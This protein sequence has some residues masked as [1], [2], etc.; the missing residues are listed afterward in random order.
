MSRCPSLSGSPPVSGL[1]HPHPAGW[2]TLLAQGT[3]AKDVTVEIHPDRMLVALKGAGVVTR[4]HF[5]GKVALDGCYWLM[6]DLSLDPPGSAELGTQDDEVRQGPVYRGETCV[7]VF[8][9][10]MK[11]FD[12]LWESVYRPPEDDGTSSGPQTTAASA[13]GVAGG[14]GGD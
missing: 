13:R 2:R 12:T 3:R 9:E 11:P 10:K 14:A 4:G 5:H 6:S 8:L 7:Q 1:S